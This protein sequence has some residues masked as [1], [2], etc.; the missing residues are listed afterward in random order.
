MDYVFDRREI[1]CMRCLLRHS[2]TQEQTQEIR[3]SEGMQDAG[4]ILACWGQV[5]LRGKEWRS[6]AIACSGGVM[7]W[8]LYAPED[9]SQPRIL[10]SWIPFQ[11]QWEI[12]G[13]LGDGTIRLQC[14]L[15]S[16]DARI[17]S[18]RKIMIRCSVGAT[19]EAWQQDQVQISVPGELPQDVQLLTNRYPVRIPKL[20]GEK[21]FQLDED[22][23]LPGTMPQ[24]EK[25]IAYS[26]NPWVT[27]HRIVSGKLVFH[28]I[29]QLHLVYC[30]EDGKITSWDAEIP[31]SQYVSLEGELTQD[32]QA[33][34]SMA[35]T[36]LELD[37]DPEGQM[38]LKCSLIAQYL[39]DEREL[40]EL[41]EDAYSTRRELTPQVQTLDVPV[42]LE[43]KQVSVPVHQTL[44]QSA[45][46]IADVG[47]LPDLPV[48]RRTDEIHVEL[49][50]MF[51]VLYYGEDGALRGA[52]ARTEEH[53]S[54][55]AGENSRVEASVRPGSQ[56]SAAGGSGIELKGASNLILTTTGS[57]GMRMITGLTLGD[58]W[59]DAETR[60]SVILRR[61]G[62]TGLWNIARETRSTVAHIKKANNLES[63]PQEDQILLIPVS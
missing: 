25:I 7:V 28:G 38:H 21:Q 47:Y 8:V 2:R 54:I 20:A 44:R 59:P 49:P 60:P 15:R 39:A 31:I 37:L 46:E 32:A 42:I 22:L 24:A 63:E 43:H 55:P 50:G 56:A 29:G 13:S 23:N 36:A 30:S 4:Q 52:A 12:D 19:A 57:G 17:L 6:D 62:R 16:V 40:L 27:D 11:M 45:G 1:P 58:C 10:E 41:A 48:I 5:V 51:Q 53:R 3:L 33:D 61:A 35:V 14:L 18:A 26:L 34:I 9:G